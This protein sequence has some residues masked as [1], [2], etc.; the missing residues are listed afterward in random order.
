MVL[1]HHARG[2]MIMFDRGYEYA[3]FLHDD[4]VY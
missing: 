4:L 3:I 1:S 2:Y